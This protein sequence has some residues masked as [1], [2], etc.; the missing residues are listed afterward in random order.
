MKMSEF[1]KRQRKIAG[2]TQEQLAEKMNVTTQAVQNWESDRTKIDWRKL[3][4]LSEI[5][6]V[7]REK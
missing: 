3:S 1:I 5:L 2:L 7:P 4:K 6:N